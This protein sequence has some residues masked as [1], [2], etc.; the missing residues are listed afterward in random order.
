VIQIIREEQQQWLVS[1][2]QSA[3]RKNV[4]YAGKGQHYVRWQMHI[5]AKK[6]TITAQS[7]K[8]EL[9]DK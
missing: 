6:K 2:N 1:R 7:Q 4:S 3:P 5:K 8:Y 9:A